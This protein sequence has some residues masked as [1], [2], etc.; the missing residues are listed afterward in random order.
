MKRRARGY[1]EWW[2]MISEWEDEELQHC[3][4]CAHMKIS[5]MFNL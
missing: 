5:V 4:M 3:M 2:N 1:N